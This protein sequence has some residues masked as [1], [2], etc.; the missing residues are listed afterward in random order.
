MG[1]K[2]PQTLKLVCLL[3][4]V[5]WP[6]VLQAQFEYTTSDTAITITKYNGSASVVTIPS[7]INGLPVT[8][9]EEDVF[10]DCD[11]LTSVTIPSSV[12]NFNNMAFF[13]C[14]KLQSINVDALNSYYS[15]VNGVLFN[16]S[17]TT[18]I[19]C[20][21]GKAGSYT[22]PNSVTGFGNGAFTDCTNLTGVTIPDSITCIGQDAFL[23][24]TSLS[25]ITIPNSVTSIGNGALSWCYSLTDITIPNSV[26]NIDANAFRLD[27]KLRAINIGALN[28]FYSSVDGVLFNKSQTTLIKCPGGKDGSYTVPDSVT[29][30]AD[31]AFGNCHSLTD[32]TIGN[33]VTRI[34]NHAFN[35]CPSVHAITVDAL[36]SSY[37]SVDGLLFNKNQTM[38]IECPEQS[39][40]GSYTVPNS[41]TSIG[42]GAFDDCTNL[43]EITIPDGVTSIG[44]GVFGGCTRLMKV[45][46][47]GDIPKVGKY[48]FISDQHSPTVY[49]LP[50]KTGWGATFGGV[51]TA[52]WKQ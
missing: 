27:S 37:S 28:F 5:L 24:C 26:T 13:D 11:N 44:T 42:D 12:T 50:G 45:Y 6:A 31:G 40:A 33:S 49:H 51:P 15:S 30:I 34:G 39:K 8:T 14:N 43:T 3:C 47:Q 32:I 22:I 7:I 41:V 10:F 17:Q 18:L 23:W 46:F 36:N 48:P 29:N 20:P 38:L 4:S 25:D 19:L 9:I 52:L 2:T 1:M 35:D 16:K 21:E